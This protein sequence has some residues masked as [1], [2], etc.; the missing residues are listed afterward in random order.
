MSTNRFT[1]DR[2]R[3]FNTPPNETAQRKLDS[4]E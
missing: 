2:Q 3:E 4:M 1:Q